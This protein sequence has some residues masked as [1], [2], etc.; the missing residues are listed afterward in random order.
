MKNIIAIVLAAGEG[1]RMKS[2]KVKVLHLV[3][4]MPMICHV[5]NTLSELDLDRIYVVVGNQ[6]EKVIEAV[7]YKNMKF[8]WQKKQLGT[9]HAVSQVKNMLKNFDGTV[10][11]LCGDTPLIKSNTLNNLL[12]FHTSSN[13]SATLLTFYPDNL[14]GYGRILRD[15]EGNVTGII[16]ESDSNKEQLKI[17][18]ANSGTYCFNWRK[19]SQAIELL[20]RENVQGEL[21]LT[22]VIK[23]FSSRNEKISTINVE[24]WKE[25][26]GI[27]TREQLA[28]ANY[29]MN[30]R[31][32][33]R[34]MDSGVT[35]IDP[36]STY[37]HTQV[38][39]GNDS[40][41]YPSTFLEGKTKIGKNCEIGPFTR[42][43][44][45]TVGKDSKVTYSVVF[46]SDI[47]KETN[48]GPFSHIRPGS[49]ISESAKIGSFV[50][51]K[52]SYVGK[53]SKVPHLSYIGDTKIGDKVNIGAGTVTV[54]YDGYR[55]HKTLIED[56]VHIG[57]D[58]MLVAPIKIGKGAVTGAG[59]VLTKDV[60]PDSLALERSNQVIKEGW[61]KRRR[62]L[63][64]KRQSKK[65]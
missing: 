51:V 18:E 12:N 23:L 22:D 60:P 62:E 44:N 55:K 19:L 36:N 57:S 61:A 10:I 38:N 28:I 8:V 16:E 20:N 9:G 64:K 27:N 14:S 65:R 3:S 25:L 53:G 54:N 49:E 26:I 37:I 6:G 33:K 48:I 56:E 47:K 46:N 7:S 34:W 42:L 21:Y 32:L 35:I 4:G 39:I 41:I 31:I 58:S 59:S 43:V 11:V 13:S 17:R 1:I 40:I 5:I 29:E 63:E 30:K 52:K 15:D 2:E 45:S 50:E 24:N